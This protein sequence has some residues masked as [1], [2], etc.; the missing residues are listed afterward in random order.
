MLHTWHELPKITD[1][2]A[3]CEKWQTIRAVRDLANKEIEAARMAGKIGA[4]LEAALTI[5]APT[6]IFA[7]LA[8]LGDDLKFVLLTSKA[9]LQKG[10]NGDNESEAVKIS[11][12]SLNDSTKKCA[13]CWHRVENLNGQ[14]LCLRCESALTNTEPTRHFA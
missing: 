1:L 9:T 12:E 7:T 11:V 5:T 4:S 13:R 8:T 6:A 2:D 10:E 3:L 14:S